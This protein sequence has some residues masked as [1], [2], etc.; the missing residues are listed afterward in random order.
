MRIV[1]DN[2]A[3]LQIIGRIAKVHGING[4]VVL[5]A[6]NPL[7]FEIFETEQLFILIDGLAVPF[8]LSTVEERNDKTFILQF[9]TVNSR[10]EAEDLIGCDVCMQQKKKKGRPKKNLKEISIIGYT[11][12]DQKAGSIGIV[13]EIIEYPGHNVLKVVNGKKEILIPVHED[14]ILEIDDPKK[15][16]VIDAPK[17]L[18]DLY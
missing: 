9:D 10:D 18:L 5:N 4:E 7:K 16:I 15:Q 3:D 13:E 17:G 6:E 1:P 14:I 8:F 12:F 11:V 2:T